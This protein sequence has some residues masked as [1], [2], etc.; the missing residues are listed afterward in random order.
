MKKKV[1]KNIVYTISAVMLTVLVMLGIPYSGVFADSQWLIVDNA[2]NFRT[3]ES[4]YTPDNNGKCR[5]DVS[6]DLKSLP[7]EAEMYQAYYVFLCEESNDYFG[8]PGNSYSYTSQCGCYGSDLKLSG[9]KLTF[10]LTPDFSDGSAAKK[11]HL[12]LTEADYYN[13]GFLAGSFRDPDLTCTFSVNNNNYYIENAIK[14][15]KT[16]QSV[17]NTDDQGIFSVTVSFDV[18]NLPEKN[19]DLN[20]IYRLAL[21]KGSTNDN[22]DFTQ[23]PGIDINASEL[24]M[25]GNTFTIKSGVFVEDSLEKLYVDLGY[26]DEEDSAEFVIALFN[27]EYGS[28]TGDPLAKSGFKVVKT[29]VTNWTVKDMITDIKL[30]KDVYSAGSAQNIKVTFENKMSVSADGNYPSEFYFFVISDAGDI[31]ASQ[32]FN[33]EKLKQGKNQFELTCRFTQKGLY[34]LILCE[35][36]YQAV[37]YGDDENKINILSGPYEIIVKSAT[38]SEGNSVETKDYVS[39]QFLFYSKDQGGS[40]KINYSVGDISSD[41]RLYVINGCTVSYSSDTKNKIL[42]N[43]DLLS[44][45]GDFPLEI[46]KTNSVTIKTKFKSFGL[47]TVVLYN[48]TTKQLAAEESFYVVPEKYLIQRDMSKISDTGLVPFACDAKVLNMDLGKDETLT[49]NVEFPINYSEY[50]EEFELMYGKGSKYNSFYDPS[51]YTNAYDYDSY[52]MGKDQ[53]APDEIEDAFFKDDYNVYMTVKYVPE[54]S[55]EARVLYKEKITGMYKTHKIT[56]NSK[57]ILKKIFETDNGDVG[58]AG[59]VTVEFSNDISALEYESIYNEA[60]VRFTESFSFGVSKSEKI[61]SAKADSKKTERAYGEKASFTVTDTLG[62]KIFADIYKGKKKI[63][64]VEGKCALNSDGTATGKIY[65]DLKNSKGS[66]CAKG[67]YKAKIYT[68]NEYTVYS[69]DGK[70]TDKKVKSSKKTVSF[71]LVKPSRKLS[72]SA[73]AS[74]I[75]GENYVYVENPF[76]AINVET[77]IGSKLSIKVKNS[78]GSTIQSGVFESGKGSDYYISDLSGGNIKSGK[79]TVEVKAETLDK[80]S[81]TAT[82]SFEV[83]NMPKPAINSVSVSTSSDTGSGSLSFA[84][85]QSSRVKVVVKSGSTVKQ[86]VIDQNYS[87]GTIKSSFSIGGYTPG[88]YSIEITAENSGGKA[89]LTKSFEVK[90]KPV[91]VN[92]PSISTLNIRYLSGGKKGDQYQCSFNYTGKNA[93]VVIDVMYNDIEEIVYTYEGTTKS[94]S[95]TF[96]FTWDG[97]KS[98]GFKAWQ[99]NYTMRVYLVNSAGATEFMRRDFVIS[100][101]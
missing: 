6:F 21:A 33:P 37:M 51:E 55:K 77:N 88:N 3:E 50:A 60:V 7:G 35:Y 40:L 70:K 34:Y 17:I 5:I 87:A 75:T 16:E 24:K 85:T 62:G 2:V 36:N 99:G 49:F 44:K 12:W 27:T 92:K 63:A 45:L 53:E 97:F 74:G 101:G 1:T 13:G 41:Y 72:V 58:Y 15:F 8:D 91:V 29:V 71:K 42:D 30:E 43:A 47:Y 94:D 81:K 56:I 11:Y 48:M 26:T 19:S 18:E 4:S 31:I 73:S 59:V 38:D 66:Y 84:V 28:I 69:K 10:E 23:Y 64:T 65:W 61:K 39:P 32:T 9:N 54:Y 22:L 57:D 46:G 96:T 76:V 82:C 89:T 25:Y 90:K 67:S 20:K 93:K 80:E 79:Y 95:G 100:A 14:N 98:N 52:D 83:K 68:L 78:S 86:T